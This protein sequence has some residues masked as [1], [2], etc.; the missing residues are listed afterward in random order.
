MSLNKS[1]AIIVIYCPD[2]DISSN[3][4]Q[5]AL[6][7][8]EVVVVDNSKIPIL[9]PVNLNNNITVIENKCNAGIA[10]ALN[11]GVSYLG[12]K[13]YNNLFLFDQDSTPPLVYFENM[14]RFKS[15]LND[16]DCIICAPNFI[17]RNSETEA[18]FSIV[19]KWTLRNVTCKDKVENQPLYVSFAITSGIL[20]DYDLYKEVGEFRDDYFI[21]HVD[22]EYCLRAVACGKKIAINC[23]LTLDHAIGHRT[24]HKLLGV[25]IKPNNHN[26]V[27]RYYIFRNGVRMTIDYFACYPAFALLS[28]AR[29]VHE[30][31]AV[32]CFEKDKLNKLLAASVGVWHGLTGKMG[33]CEVRW[34]SK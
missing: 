8:D 15:T 11:Q 23:D 5:I 10:K 20:L 19:T 12:A 34:L 33:K 25:T 22:S 7:V 24:V 6:N 9:S 17:D 2:H 18:K 1:A 14:L 21:D 30:V 26:P 32:V 3:I 13:G 31:L 29:I 4:N 16:S 28:V 27:R